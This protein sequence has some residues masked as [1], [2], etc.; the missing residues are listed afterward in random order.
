MITPNSADTPASAMKPTAVAIENACPKMYISQNPPISANGTL[1]RISTASSMR[2][3]V[4]Y[5]ST[6]M[7]SSVAGI[8]TRSLA[9]AC[10]KYSN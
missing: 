1:A 9:I 10:S 3:N 8:T 5:N 7:I 2:P 4:T 6:K